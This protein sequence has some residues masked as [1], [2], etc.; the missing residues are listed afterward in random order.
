[1]T[2]LSSYSDKYNLN[3]SDDVC[4]LSGSGTAAV[5]SLHSTGQ[6]QD[7]VLIT[8]VQGQ[9]TASVESDKVTVGS[10]EKS[11]K[12]ISSESSINQTTPAAPVNAT[13]NHQTSRS[14]QR[15]PSESNDRESIN[16]QSANNCSLCHL[17]YNKSSVVYFQVYF[18]Y[19]NH[20]SLSF[21]CSAFDKSATTQFLKPT[22]S[23]FTF[24]STYPNARYAAEPKFLMSS[25]QLSNCQRT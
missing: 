1:M 19:M 17:P 14:K 20:L 9:M 12:S 10:V 23:N 7:N 24:R 21:F 13:T 15:N 11:T 16:P 22:T 25:S 2:V 18:S 8:H 4:V 3:Y 5:I 6:D